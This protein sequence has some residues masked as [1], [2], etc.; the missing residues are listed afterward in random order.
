LAPH[1]KN[2]LAFLEDLRAFHSNQPVLPIVLFN[3]NN[4]LL[5]NSLF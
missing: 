4:N 5:E 2:A 1:D 3:K